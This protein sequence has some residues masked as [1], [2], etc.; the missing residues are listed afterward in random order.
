MAQRTTIH[1]RLRGEDFEAALAAA[2]LPA[3]V[4]STRAARSVLVGGA[5]IG[6]A[7]AAEG[8]TTQAIHQRIERLR[9]RVRTRDIPVTHCF[10]L[11]PGG[12]QAIERAPA[13]A[14]GNGTLHPEGVTLAGQGRRAIERIAGG[15]GPPV[16]QRSLALALA[17]LLLRQPPLL[18]PPALAAT[19]RWANAAGLVLWVRLEGRGIPASTVRE[20]L[21]DPA[22]PGANPARPPPGPA[23]GEAMA[24]L[25]QAIE[26]CLREPMAGLHSARRAE[27]GVLRWCREQII[28]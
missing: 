11:P 26:A 23:A 18:A 19:L 9:E 2:R 22:L 25:G 8:L 4:P 13:I 12:W 3:Q 21:A 6:E 27:R 20:A 10:R 16:R 7:A 5:A 1:T 14:R 17:P 15:A 28:D 24:S